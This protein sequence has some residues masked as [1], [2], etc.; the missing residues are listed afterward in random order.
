M[1]HLCISLVILHIC[2][3][4]LLVWGWLSLNQQNIVYL[5]L[6]GKIV[7]F[8]KF[9]S[10]ISFL[11]FS[12]S[13]WEIFYVSWKCI[14]MLLLIMTFLVENVVPCTNSFPCAKVFFVKKCLRKSFTGKFAVWIC[15]DVS[16]LQGFSFCSLQD[17]G[18]CCYWLLFPAFYAV[19]CV[20]A[21]L[22]SV[23]TTDEEGHHLLSGAVQALRKFLIRPPA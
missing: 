13:T 9:N 10:E 21:L 7:E 8:W 14:L 16:C 19:C 18:D 17:D 3:Y 5:T 2:E 4:R 15:I 23:L 6:W 11:A 1:K 22:I 20:I 12:H